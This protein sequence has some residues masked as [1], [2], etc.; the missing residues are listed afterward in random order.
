MSE[1]Q[2]C[3]ACGKPNPGYP[4]C[5]HCGADVTHRI[6]MK[7]AFVLCLVVLVIGG[8]AFSLHLATSQPAPIPIAAI[9][10]WLDYSYL[11]VEGKVV[12]GPAYQSTSVSFEI[13]DD[14]STIFSLSKIDVEVY[15]S[16]FERI[17][18]SGEIPRVGDRVKVFGQVRS[19]V[20]VDREIRVTDFKDL[21]I[22]R[23][24]PVATTIQEI[25]RSWGSPGSLLYKRVV[26]EGVVGGV[27]P[28]S[29]AKIYTL[30]DNGAEIQVYIH[31]GLEAYVEKMAPP[32]S[33]MDR[34]RITAGV[35]QFNETPQ[36]AVADYDE[37]EVIGGENVENF[38]LSQLNENMRGK[39]VRVGGQIIFVEPVCEASSLKFSE[40]I[41][42]LDN[43]ESPRVRLDEDVYKLVKN[44]EMLRRGTQIELIGRVERFQADPARVRIQ[45]TG[46]QEPEL[47]PGFFEPPQVENF[48]SLNAFPRDNLVTVEG[49]VKENSE[50][51][52]GELPSDRLL[53]IEDNYGGRL[54]IH[55]PNYIWERLPDQPAKNERIKIV[56]KITSILGKVVVRP[57][58]PEDIQKVG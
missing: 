3:P 31:N 49:I 9:D 42:W 51:K 53:E 10:P 46:P 23:A 48:L 21:K 18:A 50:I 26:V 30:T 17:M 43:K 34:V 33:V 11:L 45:F 57:G 19:A 25:L 1:K 22:E 8:A 13:W 52:K 35:S 12:S 39:F 56:G 5:P 32:F 6:S 16:A 28:K 40:R 47:A 36:L 24:E 4:V 41:L 20:G 29:S 7:W 27:D 58:M 2:L 55:I 37:I 38:Q 54:T 15:G 14:S 44:K